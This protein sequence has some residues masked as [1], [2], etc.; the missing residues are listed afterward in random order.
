[1]AHFNKVNDY[2]LNVSD[3][4]NN[5]YLTRSFNFAAKQI[6]TVFTASMKEAQGLG[7]QQNPS[8]SVAIT[9]Q[10]AIQRFSELDSQDELE[11]MHAK[12]KEM[13]GNPPDLGT[14]KRVP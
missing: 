14:K 3:G 9:S 10:M 6:T 2:T 8:V 12:L 11:M 7:Y 1:M 4:F 5:G 13:G